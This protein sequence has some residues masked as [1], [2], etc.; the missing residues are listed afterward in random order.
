MNTI[1]SKIQLVFF[2][3]LLFSFVVQSQ[4]VVSRYNMIDEGGVVTA[5]TMNETLSYLTDKNENT[6]Y[7]ISSGK[8][9]WIQFEFNLPQIVTGYTIVS[10]D[11]NTKD[12]KNWQI[13]GSNDGVNWTILSSETGVV[14]DHRYKAMAFSTGLHN[15]LIPYKFYKLLVYRTSILAADGP[16]NV[17]EWQLYGLPTKNKT[18]ITDNG[19]QITGQ[20][21]GL[22]AF[23]ETLVNLIDNNPK[24]KYTAEAK[25]LWIQ[26]ES[27]EPVTLSSYSLT[28]GPSLYN[29][30]PRSWE[31]LGSNDGQNWSMLDVQYNRTFY[32]V[33]S[34]QMR[35]ILPFVN[36]KTYNWADYS[37]KAQNTM[38]KTFWNTT[39]YYYNQAY[40]PA[41]DSLHTG[42]NYWWNAHVMDLLVDGYNRTKSPIFTQRMTALKSGVFAKCQSSTTNKWWNTF[43]DDMEWMGLATFR[44]YEATKDDVWKTSA[45]DLWNMIKGGWTNVKGGGIMWAGGSP[46]S[47]NACSNAPAM[48]LAG[49]LY[50]LTGEQTYLDWAKKIQ[51]WMADS[52]VDSKTGLVW[53]AVGNHNYGNC[54]TYNQG[55]YM[56]G[57]V[58]LYNITGEQKY[59][60]A[61]VKVADYVINPA[62]V[63]KKFSIGGILTGEGTGDGGLFKGIFMRYLQQF[64]SYKILDPDRQEKYIRYFLINGKSVWDTAVQKPEIF[65]SNTWM[66]RLPVTQKHDLATHI[67][68]TMLFEQLAEM[69]REGLLSVNNIQFQANCSK[70][71]KYFRYNQLVNRGDTNS[72]LSEIQ[73][74]TKDMESALPKIEL[75]KLPVDVYSNENEIV[76][77]NK[78]SK[79]VEYTV[80]DVTGKVKFQGIFNNVQEQIQLKGQ[81]V[82]VVQIKIGMLAFAVK[83]IIK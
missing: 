30:N 64:I 81:G 57:C 5:S 49:K 4:E 67:S 62:S 68:G 78:D 53:D 44:A 58:E 9:S 19:G 26:Y 52:L 31:I 66:D 15:T 55:T 18:D 32:D 34:N 45:I 50:K 6:A 33:P 43:Y 3:L 79:L 25:T 11:D 12:P 51:I 56:G 7:S 48:I 28:S 72:Q 10:Y 63:E 22:E 13:L 39:G 41:N 65:F 36:S 1:L 38:Y 83:L 24:N 27:S 14:F 46:N 47:K 80:Y 40:Y 71:Y 74:F 69:D 21:P 54:Y 2:L 59:L 17:A 70:S 8:N 82:Y 29:R 20:Y 37:A 60:D 77:K 16:L 35:F 76:F 61:A 42:Y 73:F 75:M 23:N